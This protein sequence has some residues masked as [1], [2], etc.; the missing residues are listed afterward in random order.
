MEPS[1]TKA[2]RPNL[3]LFADKILILGKL[4]HLPDFFCLQIP[5]EEGLGHNFGKKIKKRSFSS[6]AV[7][8]KAV[9]RKPTSKGR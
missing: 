7:M 6:G 3:G 2:I 4:D 5:V 8:V 9:G 1:A